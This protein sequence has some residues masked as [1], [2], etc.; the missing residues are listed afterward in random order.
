MTSETPLE[1]RKFVAP[2]FIHGAGAL[3]GVLNIDTHNGL[4][5]EGT[6]AQIR[7]GFV[8]RYFCG[9]DYTVE[10]ASVAI[11]VKLAFSGMNHNSK[12]IPSGSRPVS[13]GG[14]ARQAARPWPELWATCGLS[15]MAL[16]GYAASQV[17]S[18][19]NPYNVEVAYLRNFARYV[20]WPDNTFHDSRA[21]W[22]VCVLGPG[23]FAEVME[24]TLHGRTERGRSSE[25]L[26]VE[27][28]EHLPHCQILYVAYRNAARRRAAISAL[29][30]KAV[31]TVGNSPDFMREGGIIQFFVDDRVRMSINLDQARAA[32]LTI[33]TKMLEVSI[34]VKENGVI[35]KVR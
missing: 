7:Q 16:S 12:K 8:D 33:P 23:P 19:Q 3:A 11:S 35:R 17:I 28:L 10:A 31:L 18:T 24:E 9:T 22:Q 20:A 1:L 25:V 29:K 6:D 34:S 26:R 5:F 15:L 32:L 27:K 4:T 21:P 14:V 2:E 30:N 13:S